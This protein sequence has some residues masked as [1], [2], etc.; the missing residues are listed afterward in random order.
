MLEIPG[1]E[2]KCIATYQVAILQLITHI[3]NILNTMVTVL[4]GS[5]YLS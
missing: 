5:A 2:G 1:P 4:L 3:Y